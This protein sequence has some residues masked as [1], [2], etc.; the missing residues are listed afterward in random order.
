[1]QQNIL[2]PVHFQCFGLIFI[3]FMS[4]FGFEKNVDVYTFWRRG[5]GGKKYVLYICENVD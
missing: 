3:I 5:G 4:Y 1:M 2:I